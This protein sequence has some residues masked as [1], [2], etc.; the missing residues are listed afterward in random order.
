M[1]ARS[2]SL[3]HL[4]REELTKCFILY[5][6]LVQYIIG[7]KVDWKK[8]RK[9]FISHRSKIIGDRATTHSLFGDDLEKKGVD[10]KR[11]F[12]GIDKTNEWKNL[13]IYVDWQNDNFISPSESITEKKAERNLEIALFRIQSFTPIF[14]EIT[15]LSPEIEEKMRKTF[16]NKKIETIVKDRFEELFKDS[17]KH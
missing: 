3:S 7:E 14:V 8:I 11:L 9:R 15:K 17:E 12:S 6:P 10:I 1:F 13:S 5:R 4:A 2:Y 16:A